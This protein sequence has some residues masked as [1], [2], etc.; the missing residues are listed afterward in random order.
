MPMAADTSSTNVAREIAASR[1]VLFQLLFSIAEAIIP[2]LRDSV[3][4]SFMS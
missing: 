1:A 4:G 2:S 3:F